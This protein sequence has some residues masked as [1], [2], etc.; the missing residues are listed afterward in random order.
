MIDLLSHQAK[1]C[2]TSAGVL[3]YQGKVLLIKH[4]KI[5][6]WLN[7]GGH[8]EPNEAPH[9]AAEREFWEE[10]HIT[11]K[12][13]PFGFMPEDDRVEL[14]PN[15]FVTDLHWVSQENYQARTTG[16]KSLAKDRKYT[17]R[18][19]EQHLN[20]S[21]LVEPVDGVD[22]SQNVEETDGIAWF[23]PEEIDELETV[24]AVKLE[25]KEAFR[26]SL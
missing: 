24:R 11:V 18:D 20:L 19:C 17:G 15:P 23:G 14:I 16:D 8:I 22:F 3:I 7:P 10:T 25:I 1:I 2:I 9:Q 6:I 26:L 12:A 4:K 13:K 21:Y 5:G